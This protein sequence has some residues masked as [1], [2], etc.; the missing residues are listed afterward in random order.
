MKTPHPTD[1]ASMMVEAPGASRYRVKG[2]AYLGHLDYC[3]RFMPGGRAGFLAAL[4]PD[5]RAFFGQDFLPGDWYD[6]FPLA[7]AGF[8]CADLLGTSFEAFIRQ[9][10]AFQAQ[11]DVKGV[12][13]VFFLILS[14][15]SIAT[16]LPRLLFQ[17][18]SFG[19]IAIVRSEPRR[20]VA[21][22]H[23]IPARL[24]QWQNLAAQGYLEV[25]LKLAGAKEPEIAF[26]EPVATGAAGVHELVNVTMTVTWS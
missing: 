22:R 14:T 2:L 6:I 3:E 10:A 24:L 16:K 20:V 18:F 21:E 5:L 25:I 12:Y 13:R 1:V 4:P 17:Y 7:A 15:R 8:T 26:G 9:R 23:G 19:D 11:E